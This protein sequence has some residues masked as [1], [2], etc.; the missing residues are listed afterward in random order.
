MDEELQPPATPLGL[1]LF[2]REDRHDRD[3]LAITLPS[4][5]PARAVLLCR[6]CDVAICTI[7]V[8][9]LWL[10][11]YERHVERAYER[12]DKPFSWWDFAGTMALG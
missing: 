8:L 1:S 9:G 10:L 5:P 3:T 11:G 6:C 2:F 12:T 4:R 7:G